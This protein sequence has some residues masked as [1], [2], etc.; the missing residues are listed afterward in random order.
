MPRPTPNEA[1]VDLNTLAYGATPII[2]RFQPA[3]V[4]RQEQ[5]AAIAAREHED[6]EREAL[7][8]KL[9]EREEHDRLAATAAAA[10]SARLRQEETE[11]ANAASAAA[12]AARLWQEE[13]LRATALAAEAAQ[14]QR[15]ADESA[16][17]E[18]ATAETIQRQL[19]EQERVSAAVRAAE[20]DRVRAAAAAAAATEFL[21][22]EE[23]RAAAAVR[24]TKEQR[25]AE[26]R[27]VE[28]AQV[29]MQRRQEQERAAEEA[30]KLRDEHDRLAEL[31]RQQREEEERLT[32]EARS[33][34]VQEERLYDDTT[35][36]RLDHESAEKQRAATAAAASVASAAAAVSSPPPQYVAPTPV[37]G[38]RPNAPKPGRPA[39]QRYE[40]TNATIA[41]PPKS[42]QIA[43]AVVD[44]SSK[45]A[46]A[47]TGRLSVE[48]RQARLRSMDAVEGSIGRGLTGLRNLGN[49]CFMNSIIQC[50][51]AI[52]PL[53][54]YFVQG[55]YR[56]D[57]NRT[58]PLGH[59]GV[60]AEEFG[61]MAA[62]MWTQR[63]RYI[64]PRYFKSTLGMICPQFA[65]T[66]QQDSQ[67]FCS[68]LLDGLHEDLS[69]VKTREYVEAPNTEG[70]P[71][72]VAA[73]AAWA[74][75]L[76]RNQSVIVDLF[77]GQ[78]K[79]TI[80]CQ[81]CNHKS[82]TFD[83]FSFLSLPLVGRH[84]VSME[85]CLQAFS[86]AEMLTG[87]NKWHCPKCKHD[88]DAKKTIQ[89][90][91]LPRILVVHL[92]RF[93][94]E[95]P[96]RSKLDTHVE[97]PVENLDMSKHCHGETT[98]RNSK[99]V[100]THSTRCLVVSSRV[101]IVSVKSDRH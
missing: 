59:K 98:V 90:W 41:A 48:Y 40:S 28:A 92:K 57:I 62:V 58:N 43:G 79:S 67:E 35:R 53:T 52:A 33:R 88:R 65:G 99:C 3:I 34:R 10:E 78:F 87:T 16:R 23:V 14:R 24:A 37:R 50:V 71:D 20:E 27:A 81:S 13:E 101:V 76:K 38:I 94:F 26:R 54:K 25:D 51:I 100:D 2:S 85:Q 68:F 9:R 19:Q 21:R 95:G 49:T 29:A 44:R 7:A 70:V 1:T 56:H 18:A 97:F 73:D 42:R 74:H 66:K 30:R 91:R 15:W 55:R 11:R 12:E 86:K 75:H 5:A 72:N 77:Q 22:S 83:P 69:R 93:Y 32:V 47:L 4:T 45:P 84:V 89:I 8:T 31:A 61:E 39:T 63:N 82:T 17:A 46:H 6:R 64:A 96:F 80:T 36:R 60:L